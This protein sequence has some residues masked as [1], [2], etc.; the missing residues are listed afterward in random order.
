MPGVRSVAWASTLPL[1][2][3]YDGRIVLRDRG[4]ARRQPRASVRRAD[5]Q[6]VSPSTSR[7]SICRSSQAGASTT[8]T[9]DSAVPVCIVNE[10]FVRRHLDGRSPIGLRVAIRPTSRPPATPCWCARSS[11]SRA[12]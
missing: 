12:R 10:A 9:R 11:A 8:A 1:G 6:I 5:Y 4:R 7:R 3:S 2:P